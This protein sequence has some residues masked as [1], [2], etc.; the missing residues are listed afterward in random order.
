MGLRYNVGMRFR[1]ISIPVLLLAWFALI[2]P[3]PA[4]AATTLSAEIVSWQVIGLDSNNPVGGTPELF[5]VQVQI[6][7]NGSEPA[8]NVAATLTI[9]T[10]VSPSIANPCGGN[11]VVLVSP[12]TDFVGTIAPGAT[13]DAYWTVR[14]V[15]T[16]DAFDTLTPINVSVTADNAPAVTATQVPRSPA[17]C[18]QPD[19]P[20]ST[21]L[22]E[23]LISQSRN[24]VLTYS[25]IGGIQQPDGSWSVPQGSTF[26]V[27]V[28]AETA[29][30][31]NEISVPA[32][33][34][35]TGTIG[36]IST[37]FT[38]SQ[39]TL[40]DDDVYTT[41]AGG[42]VTAQYVYS[43]DVVG[44][45]QLSQLIY[46]CSGNSFHYNSDYLIDSVTINIVGSPNIVLS[47]RATPSGS[48]SP[49]DVL[50]YTIDYRNDGSGSATNF[51]LTD[52]VDPSLTG[53]TVANGGTFDSATRVVTWNIGTVGPGV[54]GS[55]SF[56]A[57]VDDFAGGR[58]IRNAATGDADQ[59]NPITTALI[60]S[61]VR[62]TTPVTGT[63]SAL[64]AI[65]GWASIG[66]GL[67]LADRKLE[68][69]RLAQH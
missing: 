16:A 64:L 32:L 66:F 31:Y 6:T 36:P 60:T 4:N 56:T 15:R 2:S 42:S 62:Q 59:F 63:H 41:N 25:V 46:D 58:T 3:T 12:S 43:A 49:G 7:N 20:A 65:L 54:S 13:V 38:F 33:V 53:V 67:A 39:G 29:V 26:T 69:V 21:L 45:L 37:S 61:A 11:C 47:K 28:Q 1:Q 17:P 68:R 30:A 9:G 55:V 22:V 44:T 10:S 34:N 18:G 35:P 27:V 19:T 51:V 57:T 50:T 48:I 52:S 8:T 5:L 24:D 14:V 40:S 23:N